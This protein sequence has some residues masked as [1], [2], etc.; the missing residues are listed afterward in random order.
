MSNAVV[1]AAYGKAFIASECHCAAI[2][3]GRTSFR[4]KTFLELLPTSMRNALRILGCVSSKRIK[5]S[6]GISTADSA[7]CSDYLRKLIRSQNCGAKSDFAASRP[8]TANGRSRRFRL[9][10]IKSAISVI[11]KRV[12]M[13]KVMRSYVTTAWIVAV[14]LLSRP[15]CAQFDASECGTKKGRFFQGCLFIPV[16][17]QH[18]NI[19]RQIFS[20][21][22]ENDGWVTME[23]FNVVSDPSSNYIAVGFSKDDLMGEEPVT[24]CA[25]NDANI[26]EV[27]L[28]YNDGKS[29]TPLNKTE[30]V[31]CFIIF[32]ASLTVSFIAFYDIV[33]AA[34]A[35][36]SLD[37]SS[38][39][40]PMVAAGKFNVAMF[41][42]E[43]VEAIK[44]DEARDSML[45]KKTR[46]FFVRIHGMVMLGAWFF[47]IAT[48][49]VSARYLR[50]FL[51]TKSP[52]GL[53][54]WF[55]FTLSSYAAA[56]F[57]CGESTPLAFQIHR[58]LNV[59]GVVAML[60]AVLFAFI[61]KGWR[62][63]GPAVGRSEF[64]N[65]SPGA[66]H[67]LIGAV[68]VGLAV[69]QPLGALL[70]CA[71][72]A[73]ARPIFNWL[74]RLAGAFA[75]ALAAISVLIAAIFFH[76]WS[77]RGWAILLVVIYILIVIL[78]LITMEVIALKKRRQAAAISFEMNSTG[79]LRGETVRVITRGKEDQKAQCL[80]ITLVSIFI[81]LA[82]VIAALLIILIGAS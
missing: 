79:Q 15:S 20:F 2:F 59:L 36:H 6:H 70:R 41:S 33:L 80:T 23:I 12:E 17:C 30:Q 27:H 1:T 78:F 13:R 45:S 28:S 16:S 7:L 43:P 61:G 31:R 75:F 73:K 3:K 44:P 71:P 9:S 25:F 69:A 35:V 24:H 46:R 76:V 11:S 68:S 48:A 64:T 74:H 62:W 58:S 29:N 54:I 32:D 34:L 67:S 65:T 10:T 42:S 50:N 8:C 55:H 26:A 77:D 63:T 21:A 49:I 82:L 14:L 40:F 38:D 19:C 22:P 72:D 47:F 18:H 51:P 39:D 53:R 5:T 57:G 66:V 60:F 81:V 37:T 52:F 56:R 4:Q